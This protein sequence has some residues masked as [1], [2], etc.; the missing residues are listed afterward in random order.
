[1]MNYIKGFLLSVLFI[2]IIIVG[3]KVEL[4]EKS[5]WVL[6]LVE[7]ALIYVGAKF[8]IWKGAVIGLV[9]YTVIGGF[10][11]DVPRLDILNETIRNQYFHVPMWFAMLILMFSSVIF[12]VRYLYKGSIQD[13][14]IA[15]ELVNSGL[16]VG[17]L[18]ITTGMIWAQYSWGKFW[19]GDPKQTYAAIGL[20]VYFAYTVLRNSIDNSTS[21]ARISAVYNIFAFPILFVLLYILPRMA[22]TSLHPGAKGNPGFSKFDLDDNMKIVFYPAV[23]GWTLLALW[24]GNIRMRMRKVEL[25]LEEKED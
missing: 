19:S 17:V 3:Y 25:I 9:L 13:D 24:I 20:L 21:K 12:S 16:V 5:G 1:M 18:G 6:L 15:T 4:P 14:I 7:A 8:N 2:A 23:I 10:L 22:A 11:I